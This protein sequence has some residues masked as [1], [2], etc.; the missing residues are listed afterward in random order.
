LTRRANHLHNGNLTQLARRIRPA[1]SRQDSSEGC[2]LATGFRGEMKSSIA[3]PDVEN[4][5]CGGH[6]FD[7]NTE[8]ISSRRVLF[9]ANMRWTARFASAMIVRNLGKSFTSRSGIPA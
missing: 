1:A 9:R 5:S 6:F 4:F 8:D 2:V 3:W 7:V